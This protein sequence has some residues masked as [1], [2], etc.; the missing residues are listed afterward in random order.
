MNIYLS[1]T[2]KKANST[3]VINFTGIT[4]Y[5]C[6][7]K[8]PSSVEHP[9][10]ILTNLLPNAKYAYIPDFGRYY[11]VEDI[12]VIHNERFSYTLSVDVL[13][14]YSA[15]IKALS[16][17]CSRSSAGTDL[18]P[19]PMQSHT[20]KLSAIR[21]SGSWDANA[22]T[23]DF[24]TGSFLLTTVAGGASGAFGSNLVYHVDANTLDNLMDELF[25]ANSAIYGND[26]TDDQV[27][28]YFNPFQYIISCKWIPISGGGGGADPIQFGF[29]TSTYHGTKLTAG[30]G[31]S[32]GFTINCP[33]AYGADDFK[34]YSGDWVNHDLYVP[35]FGW[36]PVSAEFSGSTLNGGIAVDYATG[37]AYLEVSSQ[38]SG[39]LIAKHVLS[40]SGQLAV[41]VGLSQLS[42]DVSNVGTT[43]VANA[44]KALNAGGV[45]MI[46]DFAGEGGKVDSWSAR[47]LGILGS[48]A[49][50]VPIIGNLV[51]GGREVMNPTLA[52][53]GQNG[54]RM[55]LSLFSGPRLTT[56]YFTDVNKTS[57]QTAFNKADNEVRTLSTLSGFCKCNLS[58]V[59]NIGTAT[60]AAAIMSF[61]NG[62]VYLE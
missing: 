6:F 4:P 46:K 44:E 62:G 60:E 31:F 19:D 33:A 58:K 43:I 51:G 50:H 26:I 28:T 42:V 18:I 32:K 57:V 39:E 41:P 45:S 61:L 27:K 9:I 7:L 13:G 17:Y 47:T 36:L 2:G 54:N 25:N 40:A 29:W 48:L 5:S 14:S 49:N 12:Q 16:E 38:Y 10:V 15:A 8:T 1:T 3:A 37:E 56:R 20:G 59:P 24:S 30:F 52:S 53:C 23:I 11:F 35:G 34:S 22:P 21:T 55:S